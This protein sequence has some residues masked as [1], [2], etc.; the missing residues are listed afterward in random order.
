MDTRSTQRERPP[1]TLIDR[2]ERRA[3]YMAGFQLAL[4]VFLM[5]YGLVS[6]S[7][8]WRLL[9]PA[10]VMAGAFGALIWLTLHRPWD[11]SREEGKDYSLLNSTWILW[12]PGLIVALSLWVTHVYRG[13][14]ES[15]KERT[16]QVAADAADRLTVA[17]GRVDEEWAADTYGMLLLNGP[18]ALIMIGFPL[19]AFALLWFFLPR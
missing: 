15:A 14:L 18:E 6:P 3:L 9:V 1:L 2:Y 19:A 7:M 16:Q 11:F 8:G 12:D 13:M 5:G 4:F 17:L 10:L